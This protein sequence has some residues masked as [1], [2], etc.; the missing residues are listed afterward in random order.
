MGKL[1]WVG[2]RREGGGGREGWREEKAEGV[3]YSEGIGGWNIRGAEDTWIGGLLS[4]CWWPLLAVSSDSENIY[5]QESHR[6]TRA[7]VWGKNQQ[8]EQEKEGEQDQDKRRRESKRRRE[9]KTKK[10]I[11]RRMKRKI[12]NKRKKE[13]ENNKT[14]KNKE[15]EACFMFCLRQYIQ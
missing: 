1:A 9:G 11:R 6:K 2:A 4:V 7:R 3:M 10:N 13:D 12:R 14:E 8:G 15:E 5:G